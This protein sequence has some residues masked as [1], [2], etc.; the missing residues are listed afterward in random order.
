MKQT[1]FKKLMASVAIAS[2]ALVGCGGSEEEEVKTEFS[3]NEVAL[4]EGVEFTVNS[5]ER[6]AGIEYD[7]PKEGYEYIIVNL[8]IENKSEEK[9]SYNPYD[10]KMEN[11]QGQETDQTIVFFNNDTELNSGD[12][13][14]G[15]KVSGTIVFEQPAGDTGLRLNYYENMFNEDPSI[16]ITME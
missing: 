4:Y 5:V 8:T 14:A 2:V 11:S 3:Q 9:I 13:K 1:S 7:T 15:G 6:S 12:L 10:W 16:T